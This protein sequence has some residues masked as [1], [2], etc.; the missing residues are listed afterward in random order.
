MESG[1]EAGVV[2]LAPR[3]QR[4]ALLDEVGEV[5]TSWRLMRN[6]IA[7]ARRTMSSD[8]AT[9][10]QNR[11]LQFL[12]LME[13]KV[14]DELV[15]RL[16]ELAEPEVGQLTFYFATRKLNVLTN[17]ADAFT[18]FPDLDPSSSA[19]FLPSTGAWEPDAQFRRAV[20]GRFA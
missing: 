7:M 6:F 16:S 9:D 19:L 8:M 1:G 3:D 14:R 4:A 10:F 11:D 13:D 18:Q 5:V 12:Q 15:G 20:E 2:V 17:E